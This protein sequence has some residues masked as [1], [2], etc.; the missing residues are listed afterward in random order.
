[1]MKKL[2]RSLALL[3]LPGLVA[4]TACHKDDNM[5]TN[6][7]PT[8]TAL[9]TYIASD[10]SVSIY[11]AAILRAGDNALVSG[12]DSVTLLI[13]TNE[14]FRAAGITQSTINGMPTSAIDSLLRYHI[15]NG[16]TNLA[17]GTYLPITTSL[18]KKLYGYGGSTDRNYF[19]GVQSTRVAV[20]GTK[21]VVYRLNSPLSLPYQTSSAYFNA[22]TSLSYFSQALTRAGIDVSTDTGFST[23][24]A[25]N[26]TAFRNAGYSTINDINSADS[27]QLRNILM[28]HILPGQ[29]FSNNYMGLNTAPTSVPGGSVTIGNGVSGTTFSGAGNATPVGFAGSNQLVGDNAIYQPING[30]LMP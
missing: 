11:N 16:S 14:A 21:G 8:P 15:I 20:P 25:P 30:L 19:N 17:T 7:T 23:V 6:P 3:A 28:Y 12:N 26:N 5:P 13:R 1:M 27:T 9:Q 22:D 29:Y 4:V 2:F 10:T 24:L 18:G